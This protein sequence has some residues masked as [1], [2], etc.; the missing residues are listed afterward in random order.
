MKG[1]R[2]AGRLKGC[3]RASRLIESIDINVDNLGGE[4]G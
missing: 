1:S 4:N 3:R 2:A